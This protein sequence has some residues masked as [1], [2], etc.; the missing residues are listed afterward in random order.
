MELL[1]RVVVSF[2]CF[3]K[4]VLCRDYDRGRRRFRESI[5]VSPKAFLNRR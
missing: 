1:M 4:A 5:G 2:L 3:C